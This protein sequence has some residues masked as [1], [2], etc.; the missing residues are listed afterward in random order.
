[1]A[2]KGSW[3]EVQDLRAGWQQEQAGG[4]SAAHPAS[5]ST[6]QDCAEEAP[7]GAGHLIMHANPYL[8]TWIGGCRDICAAI[9]TP[10]GCALLQA[11]LEEELRKR[12][13]DT[14]GTKPDLIERL[15]GALTAQEQVGHALPRCTVHDR[16]HS[17]G[18]SY[19]HVSF[20]SFERML[21]GP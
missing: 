10:G 6:H 3:L 15:H 16:Q 13:L 17:R 19:L 2:T 12:S 11:R 14:Q 8:T 1:M 21:A 5:A 18:A 7:Q 9:L 20:V 4:H